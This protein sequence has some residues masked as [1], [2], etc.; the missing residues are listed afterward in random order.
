MPAIKVRPLSS[1]CPHC[2]KTFQNPSRVVYHLAQPYSKC[3]AR[4]V[5]LRQARSKPRPDS[6]QQQPTASQDQLP[7]AS[8]IENSPPPCSSPPPL[9][10]PDHLD[11][12]NNLSPH[13]QLPPPS[14]SLQIVHHPSAAATYGQG[15][16]FLDAFKQDRFAECRKTNLYYPFTSRTESELGVFLVRSPM[17]MA[18][19]DRFLNLDMV[20]YVSLSSSYCLTFSA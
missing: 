11:A 13:F 17:S 1:I 10:D 18:E 20:C 7:F 19:I 3:H 9:P 5:S 16:T 2:G 8:L 4:Q 14:H 15:I 6:K 12:F